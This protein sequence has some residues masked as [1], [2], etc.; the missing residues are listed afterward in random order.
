LIGWAL[1][2]LLASS[3][4]QGAALPHGTADSVAGTQFAQ[5][6][7]REQI[8]V[9]VPATKRPRAQAR[10]IRWREGRGPRCV[11]ASMIRGAALLGQ[12]S[13]DLLLKDNRRIR[14]KLESSCPALDYYAGFYVRPTEDGLI[15]AERD[16]IR[17]R[18]GG[19]CGIERFARLWP[20]T[21]AQPAPR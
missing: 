5:L 8:I 14:I 6:V 3:G 2:I 15:C 4:A 9:R 20:A 17:S 18:V 10:P 19:Q 11:R 12:N 13:V 16:V 21:A 7:V 1:G